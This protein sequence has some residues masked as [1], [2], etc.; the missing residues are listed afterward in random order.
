MRQQLARI[1][2]RSKLALVCTDFKDKHYFVNIRRLSIT[3]GFSMQVAHGERR[4]DALKDDLIAEVRPSRALT[5]KPECVTYFEFVQTP[6]NNL[7]KNYLRTVTA[8]QPEWLC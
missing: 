5:F 7:R 6:K 8:I 1:M 2:Q 3:A 4:P